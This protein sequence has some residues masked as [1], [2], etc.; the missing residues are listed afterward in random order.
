MGKRGINRMYYY[1]TWYITIIL[2]F[3]QSL[4]FFPRAFVYSFSGYLAMCTKEQINMR[5]L[6]QL[7]KTPSQA[8]EMLQ[9]V[10]GDN[11]MTCTC[12]FEWCK[13]FKENHKEVKDDSRSRRPSTSSSEVNI[14]QVWQVMYGDC[15]LTV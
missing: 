7:E 1:L 14:K 3:L 13:R 12:V 2:V 6:V 11:T 10:Y 8:L 9:R 4:H 15:W 5:F